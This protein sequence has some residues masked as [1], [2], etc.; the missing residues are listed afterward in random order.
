[1]SS[2]E[3][4]ARDNIRALLDSVLHGSCHVD[5][6][7]PAHAHQTLLMKLCYYDPGDES[8]LEILDDVFSLNP[9]VNMRDHYDRTAFAHACIAQNYFMVDALLFLDST[10]IDTVDK[11]ECTPL[12]YAIKADDEYLVD[13]ILSHPKARTSRLF[14]SRTKGKPVLIR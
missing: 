13:K 11:E 5:W 2:R 12:I 3:D 6:P 9:D 4:A 8:I 14:S 10:L 7:D 1:M